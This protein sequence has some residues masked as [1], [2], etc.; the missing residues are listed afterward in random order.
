[1][2]D[3]LVHAHDGYTGGFSSMVVFDPE[4][5]RAAVVLADTGLAASGGVADV[6]GHLLDDRVPLR[7]PQGRA[8]RPEMAATPSPEAL[9]GYAGTYALMPVFDLAVR[10][11]DGVLHAQ[12]TGQ[13]EF[14]LDPVA[15][16]VF[17]AADYGIEIEFFR[18]D[19]G[20]V[21][22]LDLRQAGN[23]MRGERQ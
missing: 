5:G 9:R 14:P 20:D 4:R 11:R 8:D 19:A 1:V 12:A 15:E 2:G 3:R 21:T 22:G 23:V 18:D 17:E 6:A 10:E 16:D 7:T 13:G